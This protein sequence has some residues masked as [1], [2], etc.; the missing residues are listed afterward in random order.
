LIE[1]KSISEFFNLKKLYKLLS[2]VLLYSSISG[3]ALEDLTATA[4]V[5]H[6]PYK[7]MHYLKDNAQIY[8]IEPIS[9]AITHIHVCSKILVQLVSCSKLDDDEN[10][11]LK[12][13]AAE[14]PTDRMCERVIKEYMLDPREMEMFMHLF[15]FAYMSEDEKNKMLKEFGYVP[16]EAVA[17]LQAK[18]DNFEKEKSSWAQEKSSLVKATETL[19]EACSNLDLSLKTERWMTKRA[20]RSLL[21]KNIPITEI[22][23]IYPKEMVQDVQEE[24]S[25]DTAM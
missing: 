25:R 12:A 18:V 22:E 14:K 19:S 10:L 8:R 5:T 11:W 17:E 15:F 20:I 6:N 13:Y 3:V 23:D 2:Q 7:L 21:L 24:M 1:F 9:D 16:E 4:L